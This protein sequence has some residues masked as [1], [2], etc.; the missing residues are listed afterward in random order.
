MM[1]S[2]PAA[3]GRT[4]AREAK[5]KRSE[6]G[7]EAHSETGG[8][9]TDADYSGRKGI[10]DDSGDLQERTGQAG[11]TG[12]REM[13]AGEDGGRSHAMKQEDEKQINGSRRKNMI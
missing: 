4:N 3:P 10:D 5:P 2:H 8:T 1:R 7:H 13:D 12:G 11:G 6:R 9:G